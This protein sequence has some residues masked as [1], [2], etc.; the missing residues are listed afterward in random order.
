MEEYPID[1]QFTLMDDILEKGI[2]FSSQPCQPDFT[3]VTPVFSIIIF[4]GN[5]KFFED[6]TEDVNVFILNIAVTT[7]PIEFN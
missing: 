1:G 4:E 3:R 7:L 5:N 6:I 2:I